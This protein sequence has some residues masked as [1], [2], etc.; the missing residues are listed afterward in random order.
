MNHGMLWFD[1]NLQTD[2]PSKISRAAEY[3]KNKYGK[4]PT[5][6]FVNPKMAEKKKFKTGNVE[7]RTMNTIMPNHLWI[8]TTDAT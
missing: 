4:S 8:G 7:V 5:L 3:Y 1:N 6:C 2:L